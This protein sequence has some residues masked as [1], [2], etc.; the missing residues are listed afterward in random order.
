VISPDSIES[1]W[2]RKELALAMTQG[3]NQRRVKVLP[4]KFR[5]APMPP[6]L[7]DTFYAD[8]DS[9]GIDGVAQALS[10]AIKSHQEGG[11]VDTAEARAHQ[12][13]DV[14]PKQ[15]E[16]RAELVR[17]LDGIADRTFDVLA[18]WDRCLI[19][20]PTSDLVDQQRRLVYALDALPEDVR[21]LLPLTM[22]LSEALWND[23]LRLS[24]PNAVLPDLRE[25][26][27]AARTH[28]DQGL[29]LTPRWKLTGRHRIDP[30]GEGRDAVLHS[31]DIERAGEQR[32]V[33]VFLSGTVL[34]VERGLPPEIVKAK[35]TMGR[36]AVASLL[37]L[38]DPPRELSITTRGISWQ[39]P[40]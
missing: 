12:E 31:W 19:G 14:R 23:D 1:E 34:E 33:K 2:C 17:T 26:L 4:V 6:E 8:A 5:G 28:L 32:T 24:A 3:I 29:P 10:F 37:S 39:L 11:E 30:N 7:G 18:Q 21:A 13:A 25:E 15:P 38:E 22:E 20:A 27:R 9:F 40:N 36:S 35:E 16:R